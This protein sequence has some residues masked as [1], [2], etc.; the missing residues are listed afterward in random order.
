[1]RRRVRVGASVFG[2]SSITFEA[3]MGAGKS[4]IPP[5]SSG[6]R[7][8]RWR[9]T[10]FAPSTTT[11]PVLRYTRMTFPTW[12]LSSPRTTLTV[13]PVVTC[14]FTR[15]EFCAC[16]FCPFVG[17]RSGFLYLRMRML[18]HIGRELDDLHVLLLA[19]LAGDR[20]ED[21]RRPRL[22]RIIDDH[23]GVLVEADVAAILPPRLLHRAHDD[24]LRDVA[25]LYRAVR[26][27]IF[28]GHD[29]NVAETGIAPACS[30]QD[31]D[32]ECRLGARVVRNLHHRLLLDHGRSP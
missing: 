28:H 12:P 11:R 20:T 13:S 3:W 22:A 16:R 8:L 31:A 19:Q 29:D 4:T 10:M 9:F 24:R 21:T 5:W 18:T 30:A 17:A 14:S 25:L 32:H 1:M 26:E 23:H 2:S 27:R 7:A 6:L 15:S